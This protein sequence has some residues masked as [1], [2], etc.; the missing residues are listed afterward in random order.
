MYKDLKKIIKGDLWDDAGTL[1]K[2]SR[3][4]SLFEVGPEVVISPKD[5]RDV[6]NIVRFVNG[7]LRTYP[8]LSITARSA[9]TDMTGGPLSDSIVLDFLRYFNV[10]KDV[11]EDGVAVVEPGVFYRDFEKETLR[12]D[13]ILPSY[14]AS[15]EICALGGMIN[16]NSGGEKSLIYGKTEKYVKELKVVLSDGREY[17]LK[18]LNREELSEKMK[19]IDFEGGV[20]RALFGILESNYKVVKDARPS[21]SKNSVGYNIW[22]VW[23]R[24]TGEFDMTKLFV[25]AQGTL[26]IMTEAT[27]GLVKVKPRSGMLVVFMKDLSG[28]P[29]LV[30][31]ILEYQPTSL[32]SFDDHTLRLFLRFLP[33]FVKLL[34]ARNI[35]SLLFRFV[36]DFLTIL[37]IGMPKLVLLVEFE[38]DSQAEVDKKLQ[39]LNKTLSEDGVV[40]RIAKTK[41]EADKYWTVRRESFNLLRHKV[42]NKQTAPFIDDIIV[43]PE[44]FPEFLPELYQILDK[45]NLLYTIAGHMGDGN[46]HIIP[47][48]DLKDEKERGKIQ[49]AQREVYDLVLRYKGSISA[50][51]NDGLV[52]GPYIS[53]MF[54]EEVFNIF[55]DIKKVFD[56]NN[57]FNPHKKTDSSW[58]Y[59]FAHIIKP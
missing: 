24:E 11:S 39:E 55:R 12:Q 49:P 3:D 9:G 20:Y 48:M 44:F 2:F 14:P 42:L 4:A 32:E 36:P 13:Y 58:E 5:V 18:K 50:E 33:G 35:F 26:G 59:S 52:R 56:P 27:L 51:H 22:D 21:V 47:L 53:M 1:S 28:L 7:N 10:T 30:N 46:I 45:Y 43:K 8:N 38:D 25:G 57:I 29:G 6:E 31:K 34:G 15:R 37:K 41:A 23:D 54:G 40:T 16:N 19:Q 17:S